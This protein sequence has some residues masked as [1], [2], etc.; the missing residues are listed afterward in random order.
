MFTG[1]R[2]REQ[3]LDCPLDRWFAETIAGHPKDQLQLELTSV[4][5]TIRP[6][7]LSRAVSNVID[8]DLSVA[9]LRLSFAYRKTTP[10]R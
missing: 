10:M 7:A 4:Q 1:A 3:P 8:N 6:V 9:T 2:D 5:A